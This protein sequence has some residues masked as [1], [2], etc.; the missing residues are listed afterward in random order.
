M[1]LKRP[2]WL[3]NDHPLFSLVLD[4]PVSRALALGLLPCTAHY[5]SHPCLQLNCETL[6]WTEIPAQ[7]SLVCRGVSVLCSGLLL[8][9]GTVALQCGCSAIPSQ[10][11]SPEPGCCPGR[12][13]RRS[14]AASLAVVQSGWSC[15]LSTVSADN[16]TASEEPVQLEQKNLVFKSSSVLSPIGKVQCIVSALISLQTV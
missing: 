8:E 1:K 11:C 14:P 5:C 16:Y 15:H 7:V 12:H 6:L 10:E 2:P 13:Q 3:C 4:L 9:L